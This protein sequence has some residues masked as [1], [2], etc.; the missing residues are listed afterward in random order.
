LSGI[1]YY[2]SQQFLSKSVDETA[3]SIGNDYAHRIQADIL[4]VMVHLEDV[5]STPAIQS[6]KDP[7]QIVEALA[8]AHKRI[9][10]FDVM[11]FIYPDGFSYRMN[12]STVKLGD[13]EYFK[14][15]VE[16]KK[17]AVSNPIISRMT[18]KA[19]V[20]LAVPVLANGQLIGVV[21]GTYPM[22][23]LTEL[24][25]ELKFK[26]SGYGFVCDQSGLVIAHST[27]PEMVNKLN[28]GNK[29]VNEELKLNDPDL[30]DNLMNLFKNGIDKQA[31]GKYTFGGV[32]RI[33]IF[34]PVNLPGGQSWVMAVTAPAAEVTRETDT[35]ARTM[36]IVSL[37]FIVISVVF[38]VVLSKRFVRPIQLIR[39]EC[40]LLTQGDFREMEAKV[41]SEDEVGQLAQGF[42]EMRSTLRA[43]VMQVHSQSDQLAA[44]SE[45]LTASAE[46]SANAA[47]QV[48]NSI[49]EIA[50]G[51]EKQ[52]A[53]ATNI[54]SVAE[55]MSANTEQISATAHE[56]SQIALS[57]SEEAAQGRQA[58]EQAVDQMGQI[59]QGSEAVQTAIVELAKGSQEIS[60]IANLIATIAGQTNLLAL[61]AAIEAARAGE[62]GRGFA[63]VAEE[64]RKLAEE[65][66][67]AAQKIGAL[68]QKNQSNMDQAVAA[69]QAG[70]EGVKAGIT[71]VNSAGETF[72]KIVGSIMHLSEQ[73]KEIS[74]AI[75]QMAE[76]SRT[77]LSSI[78]EIDKVSKENAGEAQTVSAATEEQSA[79]MQE[80]AASSQSLAKLASD[81]QAAV[82][83]F[84]L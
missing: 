18:G 23:G 70:A 83:K 15:V 5:A 53:S 54:S 51:T 77:L 17:A 49:T 16:T 27:M 20:T 59:S 81:L 69:T 11:N 8:A 2:L 1:S 73:I 26:D 29:K 39:D 68:I 60:E 34:T 43:L 76:G 24:V 79:S 4:K 52:A 31:L 58:V 47:N 28:L 78:Q 36:L 74:D 61:N 63:V 40:L 50:T 14:K 62:L 64:V 9:G 32:T 80:I 65:S 3:A 22:G 46:Q 30:D 13:R 45:E 33:G 12:G 42:R 66:N 71:V 57:T 6:G 55:Q 84:Q 38:I 56:V 25:K 7:A 19:S 21:T 72:N 48:A 67:H 44:S 75:H 10:I 82:A 37:L 35:L 41:R